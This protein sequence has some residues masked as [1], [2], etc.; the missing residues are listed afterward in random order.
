MLIVTACSTVLKQK[1][2]KQKPLSRDS[3]AGDSYREQWVLT[4]WW[5]VS[6]QGSAV[7]PQGTVECVLKRTRSQHHSTSSGAEKE[8]LGS[9]IVTIALSTPSLSSPPEAVVTNLPNAAA[10]QCTASCCAGPD[11]KSISL[12]LH[13]CNVATVTICNVNICFLMILGEP[14]EGIIRFSK[15]SWPT[16]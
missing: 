7:R 13:N 10:L 12:L 16:T 2:A 6:P 3:T 4:Q 8:G 14:G 15:G 11:H 5:P 1:K 9:R